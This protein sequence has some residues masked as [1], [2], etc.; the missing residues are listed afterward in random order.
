M[1]MEAQKTKTSLADFVRETRSEISKVSWPTREET[2]KMTAAIVVMALVVGVFF[3]IVDTVL[4]Y[5]I[6]HILGMNS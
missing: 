1:S 4:G 3:L 6:S 2:M 5:V